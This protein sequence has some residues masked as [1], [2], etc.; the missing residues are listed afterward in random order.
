[1][2]RGVDEMENEKYV[3]SEG[4]NIIKLNEKPKPED[5]FDILETEEDR[6]ERIYLYSEVNENE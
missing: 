1:M 5:Y 4:E 3:I 6:V 2:E